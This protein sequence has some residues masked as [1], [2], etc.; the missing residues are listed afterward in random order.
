MAGSTASVHHLR[1]HISNIG[2]VA[3]SGHTMPR[4]GS[5]GGGRWVQRPPLG[6]SD[7]RRRRG[8]LRLK[9]RKK[10]HWCP[11][12]GCSTPFKHN[13]AINILQSCKSA[14]LNANNRSQSDTGHR[15]ALNAHVPPRAALLGRGDTGH[16]AALNAHVP[17][18]AALPGRGDT[19]HRAALNAHVPPR[20]ALPGRGDTGHRAALN[21]HVPPRAALPG[22]GDTGHRAALNAHVPL[23]NQ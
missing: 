17:P 7:P 15:A 12:N 3:D 4:R 6:R 2:N 10:G 13:M 1:L 20:A 23:P 18:R 22:R 5:R 14:F 19:G 11:L 21:A 9:V 16:R 8:F